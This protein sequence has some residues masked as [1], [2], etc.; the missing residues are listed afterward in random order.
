MT[1][2]AFHGYHRVGLTARILLKLAGLPY[3]NSDASWSIK[4]LSPSINDYVT[5]E[6]AMTS[7]TVFLNRLKS[8][9]ISLRFRPCPL[10]GS[11]ES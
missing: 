11:E 1:A 8:S 10:R 4:F 7:I 5:A 2:E 6:L 9:H 3:P